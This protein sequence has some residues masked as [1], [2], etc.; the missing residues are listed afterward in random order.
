MLPYLVATVSGCGF[1]KKL[2]PDFSLAAT[3]LK[4]HSV[5]ISRILHGGLIV[6]C[7]TRIKATPTG[8]HCLKV[9]PTYSIHKFARIHREIFRLFVSPIHC[10]TLVHDTCISSRS[11]HRDL[12]AIPY[13]WE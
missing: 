6:L 3:E 10:D 1:C 4:G 5:S 11:R 13:G 9:K 7:N 8:V 2:K 12:Y